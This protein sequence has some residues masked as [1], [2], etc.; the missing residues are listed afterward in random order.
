MRMRR[1]LRIEPARR[2]FT[3]KM[4]LYQGHIGDDYPLCADLAPRHFLRVGA[5]YRYLGGSS[6]ARSGAQTELIFGRDQ[7]GAGANPERR[8]LFTPEPLGSALH[9]ALC[10]ADPVSGA[11]RP[12]SF[13]TLSANLPC[14]GVECALNELRL[15]RLDVGGTYVF[16]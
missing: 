2:D 16:Y 15:V 8:P 10:H 9:A 3:P 1:A 11:C 13:V 7:S 14:H 6:D 5:K 12:Q 4:N